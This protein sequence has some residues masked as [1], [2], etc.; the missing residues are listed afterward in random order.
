MAEGGNNRQPLLSTAEPNTPGVTD[1]DRHSTP[2]DQQA[3]GEDHTAA[4]R[5]SSG[6]GGG[7]GEPATATAQQATNYESCAVIT[8]GG[9]DS[10]PN[11]R[12]TRSCS[13]E[14]QPVT[15]SWENI[16]VFVREKKR[17]I[18]RKQGVEVDAETGGVFTPRPPTATVTTVKNGVK[19]IIRNGKSGNTKYWFRQHYQYHPLLVQLR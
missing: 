14:H 12:I 1:A 16:N 6:G 5:R 7:S 17:K 13:M 4:R 8:R 2:R 18:G 10:G 11:A 3:P 19:Q 15:L 9:S